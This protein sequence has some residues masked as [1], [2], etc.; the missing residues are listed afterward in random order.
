MQKT[1]NFMRP[2]LDQHA[3]EGKDKK[4][5]FD[6]GFTKPNCKPKWFCR[7]DVSV[8][9]RQCVDTVFSHA[10]IGNLNFRRNFSPA[11]NTSSRM[12]RTATS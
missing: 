12:K 10:E 3:K 7:K 11:P 5:V 2:L 8:T 1:D 4:V 6:A 9:G